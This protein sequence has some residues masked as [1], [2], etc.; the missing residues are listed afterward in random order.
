MIIYFYSKLR[1]WQSTYINFLQECIRQGR[2]YKL[3]FDKKSM[4]EQDDIDPLLLT[5]LIQVHG[6]WLGDYWGSKFNLIELHPYFQQYTQ[7]KIANKLL[8]DK[9]SQIILHKINVEPI[10]DTNYQLYSEYI[11][12]TSGLYRFKS[13]IDAKIRENKDILECQDPIDYFTSA[14]E[15]TFDEL[16]RITDTQR[17]RHFEKW[18]LNIYGVYIRNFLK[19]LID[20]GDFDLSD[21]TVPL[22]VWLKC[23]LDQQEPCYK[24]SQ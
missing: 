5:R 19:K 14:I 12:Q 9:R 3:I 23:I 22:A 2:Q 6:L 11:S 1:Q 13:C 15:Q 10:V 16:N 21:E 20:Q 24:L 8:I 4:I 17:L 7:I 18:L